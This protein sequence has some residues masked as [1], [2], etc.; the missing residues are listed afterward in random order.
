MAENTPDSANLN[1]GWPHYG[2]NHSR[3][4]SI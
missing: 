2:P 3:L 4:F 1:Q